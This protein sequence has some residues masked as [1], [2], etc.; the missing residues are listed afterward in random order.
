QVEHGPGGVGEELG[1]I[2]PIRH[3]TEVASVR[4]RLGNV[5][6]WGITRHGLPFDCAPRRE[7]R[8]LFTYSS[9]LADI[10]DLPHRLSRST[11]FL[12]EGGAASG[13]YINALILQFAHN[14]PAARRLFSL[15]AAQPAPGTVATTGEGF[16]AALWRAN[17]HIGIAAHIARY[18]HRLP[19]V[20]IDLGELRMAWGEGARGT[21]P[22]HT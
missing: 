11:N 14:R 16:G 5:L 8:H 20:T 2:L 10:S 9:P 15:G 22:V 6:M 12:H 17:E 7:L 4:Q 19:E 3:H 13:P 18:Q 1:E 21:L